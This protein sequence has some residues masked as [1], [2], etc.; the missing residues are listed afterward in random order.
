MDIRDLGED[1]VKQSRPIP[2]GRMFDF[3]AKLPAPM[4]A[5]EGFYP[6]LQTPAQEES[7]VTASMR[8]HFKR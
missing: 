1:L 2:G 6:H 5:R 3:L 4:D 8:W 7:Q